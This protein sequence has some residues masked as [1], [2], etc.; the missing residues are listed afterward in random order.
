[1]CRSSTPLLAAHAR[2]LRCRGVLL[3]WLQSRQNSSSSVLGSGRA[4]VTSCITSSS[5]SSI[6]RARWGSAKCGSP[7][8]LS[9]LGSG[10]CL[11]AFETASRSPRSL[12]LPRAYVCCIASPPKGNGTM[13]LGS[14]STSVVPVSKRVAMLA[15][16]PAKSYWT[17]RPAPPLQLKSSIDAFSASS[18]SLTELTSSSTCAWLSCKRGVRFPRSTAPPPT[19]RACRAAFCSTSCVISARNWFCARPSIWRKS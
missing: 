7:R 3:P 6:T 2:A 17:R 18:D 9:K 8:T 4:F 12:S 13:C 15:S 1:M 19:F 11:T 10:S 16:M 5:R 14:K